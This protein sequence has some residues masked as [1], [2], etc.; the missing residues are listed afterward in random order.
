MLK[1]AGYLKGLR[2][3]QMIRD[4]HETW[5]ALARQDPFWAILSDEERRHGRW[6]IRDFLKTGETEIGTLFAR[7]DELSIRTSGNR[8]LD[9]GCGVGRVT[10]ALARRFNQVTGVD[11]SETMIERARALSGSSSQLQF[12]HLKDGRLRIFKDASFDF[13]YSARVL[14]HVPE[15]LIQS[16]IRELLRLLAP[17]GTLAFQLPCRTRGADPEQ[18]RLPHE[19][20]QAAISVSN[21]PQQLPAGESHSLL[22]SV[23]NTSPQRW[24]GVE[25][26]GLCQLRAANRW[27]DSQR[28]LVS[29]HDGR[30]PLKKALAAGE[31]LQLALVISAPDQPG[32]YRCE[33]TLVQEFVTWFEAHD[34]QAISVQPSGGMPGAGKVADAHL[35]IRMVTLPLEKVRA[36]VESQ[37]AQITHH[38]RDS[39][40]GREWE[41][42][43]YL[44]QKPPARL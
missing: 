27:Y 9:F 20:Y 4:L 22:V 14:Q 40:T 12:T 11:I 17:G 19:A 30:T 10:Q 18:A 2:S 7:F 13:I 5:E 3:R 24:P 38:F 33:V 15:R 25:E 28:R 41:S 37:G 29:E 21:W 43:T 35:R 26:L 6:E 23:R 44:V 1:F 32:S 8:A 16:Y 36:A 34:S 42:V 39:L 31:S